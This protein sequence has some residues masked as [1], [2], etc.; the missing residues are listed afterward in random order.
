MFLP[1][2]WEC[3]QGV[4][5]WAI[6]TD[7]QALEANMATNKVHIGT[8]LTRGLGRSN[9]LAQTFAGISNPDKSTKGVNDI[10][11]LC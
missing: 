10:V 1:A 6:N 11:L 2:C 4:E 3:S 9:T 5:F 8:E 7:A